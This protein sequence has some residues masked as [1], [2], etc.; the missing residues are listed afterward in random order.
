MNLL[1]Y[2]LHVLMACFLKVSLPDTWNDDTRRLAISIQTI[3]E[4]NLLALSTT[5]LYR[6]RRVNLGSTNEADDDQKEQ[7]CH[8]MSKSNYLTTIT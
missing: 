2:Y 4:D 7:P 5:A 8:G 1:D 3:E 6:V